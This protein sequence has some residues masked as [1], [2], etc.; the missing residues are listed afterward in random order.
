[1]MGAPRGG[2]MDSYSSW[3]N[4]DG[5]VMQSN[6]NMNNSLSKYYTVALC[7]CLSVYLS[8]CRSGVF[9]CVCVCVCVCVVYVCLSV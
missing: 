4:N 1:M 7:V 5:H 6:P 2:A 3:S 9:V 8:V